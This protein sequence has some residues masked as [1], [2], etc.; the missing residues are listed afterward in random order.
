MSN[1]TQPED[2]VLWRWMVTDEIT[3][4]RYMTRYAMTEED[5]LRR[6]PDAEKVEHTREVRRG[7]SRDGW[8]GVGMDGPK[9]NKDIKR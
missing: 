3:G 1:K 7:E 8:R 6:Y 2:L 4:K 9:W 5:A